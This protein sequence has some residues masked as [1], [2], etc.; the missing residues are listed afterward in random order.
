M[1]TKLLTD[2]LMLFSSIGV[3]NSFYFSYILFKE[4][5]KNTL[6]KVLALLL[7]ALSLR[8]GKS[9]IFYF[10]GEFNSTIINLGFVPVLVVGPIL[11]L[12]CL[13]F[14]NKIQ[15]IKRI[16]FLHFTPALFLLFFS[17]NISYNPGAIYWRIGYIF[18]IVQ[19]STYLFLSFILFLDYNKKSEKNQYD[20]MS[21]KW[22][23]L[24]I[25]SVFIIWF[26]YFL[27][28][29]IKIGPYI[30][31]AVVYSFILYII[32]YQWKTL[33]KK[34]RNIHDLSSKLNIYNHQNHINIEIIKKLEN[35]IKED[36]V[37]SDPDISISKLSEQLKIHSY[38]LSG[39]INTSYQKNFNDFINDY[40]IN[41]AKQL[42]EQKNYEDFTIAYIAYEVGFSSLSSFNS[43]FKKRV[44][45]TP[46]QFRTKK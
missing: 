26:A 37:F 24:I 4:H 31:G 17:W 32:A 29:P 10:S 13:L 46:S 14:T 9:V 43:A 42:L 39:I 20:S 7:I 38:Q 1:E 16:Q 28:F 25:L 2:L 3:I 27:H 15:K 44:K 30:N 21:S 35:I 41:E 8:V 5:K 11:F 34:G 6:N 23:L 36:K 19:K 22:L 18:I 12:Y 45:K 33:N 40:R